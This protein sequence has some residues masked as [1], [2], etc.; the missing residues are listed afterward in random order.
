[1]RE[2]HVL[3]TRHWRAP[4]TRRESCLRDASGWSACRRHKGRHLWEAVS[5]DPHGQGYATGA[6]AAG[7]DESAKAKTSKAK[8]A[9]CC[10]KKEKENV[11]ALDRHENKA[12][13]RRLLQRAYASVFPVAAL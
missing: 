2:A 12:T 8:R 7:S 5:R 1:M 10:S 11:D 4:D 6:L 9:L 13:G 3:P